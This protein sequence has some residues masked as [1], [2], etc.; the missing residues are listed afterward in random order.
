MTETDM[1]RD[2]VRQLLPSAANARPSW[3][4]V[5]RRARDQRIRRLRLNAVVGGAA[6]AVVTTI[7]ALAL[8][9]RPSGADTR[10]PVTEHFSVFQEPPSTDDATEAQL[11]AVPERGWDLGRLHILATHL[12]RFD[13]R[14]VAYPANDER[15]LCY[16][17]IG[18]R[19]T[20]PSAGYCF[21]PSRPYARGDEAGEHFSVLA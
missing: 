21:S 9:A 11:G 19:V 8:L 7:G 10:P 18:A 4:D 20:D 1:L 14:L 5:A 3:D 12:G 2:E 16:A 15:N 17:L 6:L 13:S